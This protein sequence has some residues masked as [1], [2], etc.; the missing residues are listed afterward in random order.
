MCGVSE[1]L[2]LPPR[3]LALPS[4]VLSLAGRAARASSIATVARSELRLGHVAVLAALDAFGPSSQR[5]L[6]V[7]LRQDPSDMVALLDELE[8]R[9]EARREPDPDDRR[10][11]RVTITAR[12]RR[13]LARTMDDLEAE[14]DALLRRLTAHE[15]EQLRA[16]ASKVLD[17]ERAPGQTR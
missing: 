13:T 3:L 8:R 2:A 12:G 14:E 15:R 11:R 17:P 7:R 4:Y 10:R 6:G 5:A 16:L 1:D 9:G